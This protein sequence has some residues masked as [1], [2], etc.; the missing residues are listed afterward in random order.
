MHRSR[1]CRSDTHVCLPSCRCSPP[2][3][4]AGAG[5]WPQLPSQ[6]PA[7]LA[8]SAQRSLIIRPRRR[9]TRPLKRHPVVPGP[10]RRPVVPRQRLVR[11]RLGPGPGRRLW[12][13][14]GQEGSRWA[15]R[16]PQRRLSRPRWWESW[17]VCVVGAR[18]RAVVAGFQADRS[19]QR[20]VETAQ[21]SRLY[22]ARP[23]Q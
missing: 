14:R 5:V 7:S 13:G 20:A 2:S 23:D 6:R 12:I 10:W 19:E 11:P 17:Q 16:Y 18:V 22:T 21:L 1:A 3:P 4:R 9:P 15:R 8:A